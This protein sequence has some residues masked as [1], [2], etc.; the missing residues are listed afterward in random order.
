VFTQQEEDA[1]Q[2]LAVISYALWLNRYHRDPLILGKSIDLDRRP[3][4][5][6]GVMPRN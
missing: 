4:S 1:H 3:Y 6:I 5:I 2:P